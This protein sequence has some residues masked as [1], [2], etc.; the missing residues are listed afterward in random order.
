MNTE[1]YDLNLKLNYSLG[2]NDRIYLS[3]FTGFD[4]FVKE[5]EEVSDEYKEESELTFQWKNTIGSLRWNHLFNNRL[6]LNTT[7]TYSSYGFEYSS[8]NQFFEDESP[9]PEELYFLDSRTA[10]QDLGAKLDFDFIPDP[11][12]TLRFGFGLAD[13]S[14]SPDI[15]YFDADDIEFDDDE[16]DEVEVQDFDSLIVSSE[17]QAKEAFI[18]LEDRFRLSNQIVFTPGVRVSTFWGEDFNHFNIEPRLRASYAFTSKLRLFATASKMIQ[19]LHLASNAALRLPN[20]LWFPSSEELVPQQAW[21]YEFGLQGSFNNYLSASVETYYK[22]MDNLFT[23]PSNFEFFDEINES[24]PEDLLINGYG[25]AYGIEFML[26]YQDHKR[27]ALLSY[28]LARADRQFEDENLGL[29]FPYQFDQRHQF[30]LFVHHK[31]GKGFDVGFNG[32]FFTGHPRINLSF[33]EFNRGIRTVDPNPEGQKNGVRARAYNRFDFNLGYTAIGEKLRH[34]IKI[35][36]YNGTNT[37]NIIYYEVDPED[38]A[39][40]VGA[41]PVLPSL[42]YSLKF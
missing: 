15:T 42:S 40:P 32:V 3:F 2:E 13:K 14:F 34:E 16:E 39:Y 12:H 6:F 28:T 26:K 22:K 4:D 38:S 31:I 37:N 5:F 35:G 19:Y 25:V 29:E 23:Y 27:A 41:L 20:D 1:F 7:I 24:P 36:V 9:N 17:T 33:V 8:L 11:N 10:N 18:Y 30:K 21:Q